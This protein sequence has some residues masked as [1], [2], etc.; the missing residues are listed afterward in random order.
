MAKV[1]KNIKR[2]SFE[3]SNFRIIYDINYDK[4]TVTCMISPKEEFI[5]NLN[6]KADMMLRYDDGIDTCSYRMFGNL[7]YRYYGYSGEYQSVT[8]KF[9]EEEFKAV[10][11]N[12]AVENLNNDW[13][14]KV[15]QKQ[16]FVAAK[17][18]D[19]ARVYTSYTSTMYKRSKER[20]HAKV[21]AAATEK[22]NKD[23]VKNLFTK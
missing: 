8:G 23:V 9:N 10:A 21:A 1:K 22:E 14:N 16:K 12:N 7:N 20:L 11:Y 15:L 3:N 4:E 2:D 17:M 18:L 13:H 19:I 6:H 5:E